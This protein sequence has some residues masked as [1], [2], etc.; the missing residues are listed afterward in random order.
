MKTVWQSRA[1]FYHLLTDLH[2]I[3]NSKQFE[4]K[5]SNPCASVIQNKSL[6]M[7]R[8]K[9]VNEV[10]DNIENYVKNDLQDSKPY[11]RIK[12][13]NYNYNSIAI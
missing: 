8:Q 2:M 11:K 10:L 7:L 1:V 4:L 5:M 6:Y 13:Y 3:L 9:M 12:N